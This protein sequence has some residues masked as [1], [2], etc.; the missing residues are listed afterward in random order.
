[1]LTRTSKSGHIYTAATPED[2]RWQIN[3]QGPLKKESSHPNSF[4][5]KNFLQLEIM[6]V[7]FN[8]CRGLD[9][10]QLMVS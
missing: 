7:D 8:R 3:A 5:K 9:A 6:T 1:M 2:S 4:F 10:G